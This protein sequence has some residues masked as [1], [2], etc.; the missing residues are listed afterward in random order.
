M[1]EGNDT[2]DERSEKG[3]TD[4]RMLEYKKRSRTVMTPAQSK[5]LKRYFDI[6]SFPSTEVREELARTL[7]MKP[8]TVQIWF[9]NQRQKNKNRGDF[10]YNYYYPPRIYEPYIR[11]EC[12]GLDLLADAA[13]GRAFDR[14]NSVNIKKEYLDEKTQK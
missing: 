7:G 8:R 11:G 14:Q 2:S 5:V 10:G 1:K 13:L 4:G 6:N 9:Q 3:S 12:K